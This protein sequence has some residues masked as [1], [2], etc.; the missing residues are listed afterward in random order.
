MKLS[1]AIAYEKLGKTIYLSADDGILLLENEVTTYIFELL[2]KEQTL[3]EIKE[4]V[5]EKF[6]QMN[7][8]T[9]E[10]SDLF[11]ENFLADLLNRAIIVK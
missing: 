9:K 2:K 7:E 11:I 3:T 5:K 10:V 8:Y 4:K 1:K 6:K